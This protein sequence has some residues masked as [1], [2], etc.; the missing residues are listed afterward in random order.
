MTS[1]DP[2]E[3]QKRAVAEAA[4]GL[5]EDGM[6]IGLGTGT[7]A[8]FALEAIGRR[9]RAGLRIAGIPTSKATAAMARQLGIP[10]TTF[11]TQ[12]ALDLTIDGAD[13]VEMDRLALIKGRGGALLREKIVAAASR[14]LLVIV[15]DTKLVERLG[16]RAPV[17]VEV[18]GFGHQTTARRLAA[19]G[20]EP[21]LRNDAAGKPF[22]TDGGNLL[23]DCHF[24]AIDDPGGLAVRLSSLVGV[25]DSGLFVD[26]PRRVFVGGAAGVRELARDAAVAGP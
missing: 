1:T 20:V 26:P 25:I 24:G 3:A 4:V 18:V 7:T 21:I 19:L 12:A 13:E 15:D 8:V 17:P 5:I 9:V 14:V 23:Y 22:V 6:V 2:L 16:S 11:A 10:L